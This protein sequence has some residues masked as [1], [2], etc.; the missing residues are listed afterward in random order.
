[1]EEEQ[2]REVDHEAERERQVERPPKA[3]AATHGVH[4]DVQ[5]FVQ[6]G[7]IPRDSS[8]IVSA[9]SSLKQSTTAPLEGVWSPNLF[10]TK[11]F[12]TTIRSSYHSVSEYL[13]PVNWIISSSVQDRMVVVL[14]SPYE[15]NELLPEIRQSRNV[16]LHL[17]SP[18]VTQSM[19][20]F[21]DLKFFC[22]PPLPSS[23]VPPTMHLMSQVNLWAG[24]LYISDY[25]TYLQL[26]KFLGLYTQVLWSREDICIQLDG[27][28]QPE[29]RRNAQMSDSPFTESPVPFLK[30]LIGLRRKGMGYL[31]THMGKILHARPLAEND[32]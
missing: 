1:M 27:F 10:A 15:V 16:H 30:E 4:K 6:T 3:E 28:I 23:W 29:H 5:G 26:C 24:Q 17:Y 13:Q 7:L 19:R 11:D 31:L 8:Q 18:K 21:D 9:F 2:E 20:S 25:Q 22:I 14:L 32:F 12:S